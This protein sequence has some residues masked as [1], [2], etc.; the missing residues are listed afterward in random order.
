VSL[1]LAFLSFASPKERKQRKSDPWSGEPC[2]ARPMN[3]K[4]RFCGLF[5]FM[6]RLP[7]L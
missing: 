7:G 6:G 5:Y 2:E 3:K 4:A 1:P